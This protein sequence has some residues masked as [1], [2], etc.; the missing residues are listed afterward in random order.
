MTSASDGSLQSHRLPGEIF[1]ARFG[2]YMRSAPGI[3]LT[4]P[5][6]SGGVLVR[7]QC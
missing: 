2:S 5:S 7:M 3:N 4:E 6:V 1:S